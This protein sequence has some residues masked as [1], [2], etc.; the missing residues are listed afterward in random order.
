MEKKKTHHSDKSVHYCCV[1]FIW[2]MLA[3]PS[4]ENHHPRA[5]LPMAKGPTCP[6]AKGPTCPWQR[7][8]L[9]PWQRD[10]QFL[11]QRPG[12]TCPMAKG[13]AWPMA[14]GPTSPMAKGPT[15]PMAK[16]PTSPMAKGPAWPMAEGQTSPMAKG[17]TCPMAKGQ[18]CPNTNIFIFGDDSYRCHRIKQKRHAPTIPLIDRFC[19]QLSLS[20]SY[21]L[22]A[23][24][25]DSN[26]SPTSLLLMIWITSSFSFSFL[27][28]PHQSATR[29]R[30]IPGAKKQVIMWLN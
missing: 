6:M 5:N 27:R 16:G 14:K 10:Q 23:L 15:I 20:D 3:H 18:I 22:L 9:A 26:K 19:S 17:P 7:D 25:P 13:P 28:P 21:R 2:D 29:G 12:P 11:W 30:Q 8:Q 4:G 1:C 24:K